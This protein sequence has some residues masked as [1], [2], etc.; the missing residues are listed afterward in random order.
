LSDSIQEISS[1]N[2]L[3]FFFFWEKKKGSKPPTIIDSNL[4]SVFKKLSK[5]ISCSLDSEFFFFLFNENGQ[6]LKDREEGWR[7]RMEKECS[8]LSS[9]RV[10]SRY[11]LKTCF[12]SE[13]VLRHL[14]SGLDAIARLT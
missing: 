4:R 13:I 9:L 11:S 8:T 7:R 6:F 5:V 12:F 2:C 3:N 1:V 14:E 10:S